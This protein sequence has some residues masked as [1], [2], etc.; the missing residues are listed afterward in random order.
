M[1]QGFTQDPNADLAWIVTDGSLPPGL[2]LIAS[3]GSIEGTPTTAGTFPFSVKLC[4][5]A[6][7]GDGCS[8]ESDFTITV[9]APTPPPTP[10]GPTVPSG[11]VQTGGGLAS[12]SSPWL[13]YGGGAVAA[14]GLLL[15]VGGLVRR[16]QRTGA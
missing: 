2:T 7:G 1:L 6:P 12:D 3:D 10:E 9:N 16:R 8:P 4:D 14:I 13:P 5:L 15:A 11:P